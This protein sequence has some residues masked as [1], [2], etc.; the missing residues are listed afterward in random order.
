MKKVFISICIIAYAFAVSAQDLNIHTLLSFGMI[1]LNKDIVTVEKEG[2]KQVKTGK[3]CYAGDLQNSTVYFSFSDDSSM[4][5]HIPLQF[6]YYSSNENLFFAT[7]H[8]LLELGYSLSSVSAVEYDDKTGLI[9][10]KKSSDGNYL[11]ENRVEIRK[12]INGNTFTHAYHY[13]F[14]FSPFH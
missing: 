7:M 6:E 5:H 8:T 10:L 9:C 1:P 12:G 11:K 13:L 3:Y 2:F 4:D 14:Y